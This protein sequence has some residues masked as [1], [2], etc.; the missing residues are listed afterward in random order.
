MGVPMRN[1]APATF[2]R[3][4]ESV[5]RPYL[6][7]FVMVYLDDV[8]VYSDSVEEHKEHLRLVLEALNRHALRVK[9]KKCKFFKQRI[10]F[11]GHTIQA[12]TDTAPTTIAPLADKVD[13]IRDWKEPETNVELQSFNVVNV[14]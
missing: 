2:Q 7:D 10:D 12:A 5:L 14:I 4:M 8:I 13:A 3:M 1:L 9:L 11:L 6:F